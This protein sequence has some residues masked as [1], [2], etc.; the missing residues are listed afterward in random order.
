MKLH[1]SDRNKEKDIFTDFVRDL[2]HD[3]DIPFIYYPK[4]YNNDETVKL[5]CTQHNGLTD[6]QMKKVKK[7]W[8]DFL[9]SQKLPLTEVQF[10]TKT[11]ADIFEA[12][13]NQDSIVSLRFKWLASKNIEPISKL[14]NL[15]MLFIENGTAI[16]DITPLSK[17]ENL[18]VLILGS[19]TKIKDYS[20]LS[21]LHNL[22]VFAITSYQ[23]KISET[24]TVD[25]DNF[26]KNMEK[27]EY[28][29]L[30]SARFNNIE[31]LSESSLRNLHYYCFYA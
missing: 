12:I 22:K 1:E 6:Y 2:R 11:T 13:C 10:C 27:L 29:D 5:C 23:T 19:T 14:K 25:S 7:E 16:E 15:K 24:I 18:E 17:L 4:D 30:S 21:K 31:Y 20:S 8:C 26:I 28:L 9:S 3:S